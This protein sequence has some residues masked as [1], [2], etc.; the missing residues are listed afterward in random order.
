LGLEAAQGLKDEAPPALRDFCVA[1][2]LMGFI[3]SC[4]VSSALGVGG[5]VA[6]GD[7]LPTGTLLVEESGLIY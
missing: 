7:S 2:G 3:D 5:L 1:P 4:T 6:F